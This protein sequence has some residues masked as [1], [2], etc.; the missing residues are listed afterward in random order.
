[1][2]PSQRAFADIERNVRLRDDGLQTVRLEFVLAEGAREKA[3]LIRARLQVNDESTTKF[4][5][6]KNHDLRNPKVVS[7]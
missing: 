2:H 1:V 3:S 4:G 5:L 6:G 7:D